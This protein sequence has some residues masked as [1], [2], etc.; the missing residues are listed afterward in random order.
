GANKPLATSA[1]VRSA[2]GSNCRDTDERSSQFSH[3]RS[4]VQ[5][6]WCW[7]AH[8]RKTVPAADRYDVWEV[9]AATSAH[10][11][12]VALAEGA[13]VTHAALESG[14]DTPSAFTSMFR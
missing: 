9:A 8:C 2:A 1:F 12:D 3:P 11:G 14:Y 5:S 13:K 10:A 7:E 4:A 6:D